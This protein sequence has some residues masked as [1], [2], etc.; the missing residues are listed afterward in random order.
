MAESDAGEGAGQRGP[1]LE[2]RSS[3]TSTAVEPDARGRR[4]LEAEHP[5]LASSRRIVQ[6]SG[7]PSTT[8]ALSGPVLAL[9][10]DHDRELGVRRVQH[11]APS[12]RTAPSPRRVAR[13]SWCTPTAG[14]RSLRRSAPMRAA[15]ARPRSAAGISTAGPACRSSRGS[16]RRRPRTRHGAG[17]ARVAPGEL[18]RDPRASSRRRARPGRRM[19]RGWA[20]RCPSWCSICQSA[21]GVQAAC[22]ASRADASDLVLREAVQG[23]DQ[24]LVLFRDIQS[25]HFGASILP[26]CMWLWL[27]T[28]SIYNGL[29][30]N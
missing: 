24:Q 29:I 5:G 21:S 30:S 4:R 12:S 18:L 16:M 15:A 28:V 1:A 9:A 17:D 11:A 22:S 19:P 26:S 10:R 20:L 23:F 8:K 13:P 27:V 6:P 2:A 3:G 14:A 7:R 25:V